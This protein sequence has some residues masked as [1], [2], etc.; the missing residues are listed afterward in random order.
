MALCRTGVHIRFEF[1]LRTWCSGST[2]HGRDR[3]YRIPVERIRVSS[4]VHS[5]VFLFLLVTVLLRTKNTRTVPTP[6]YTGTGTRTPMGIGVWRCTLLEQN[7]VAP[8][9]RRIA[10]GQPATTPKAT[11][12]AFINAQSQWKRRWPGTTRFLVSNLSS[13]FSSSSCSSSSLRSD[14]GLKRSLSS[15]SK[16]WP[17][18]QDRF[19]TIQNANG[20]LELLTA[21]Q[22]VAMDATR[23]WT[24]KNVVFAANA[25]PNNY[26]VATSYDT[27]TT[28]STAAPG[29]ASASAADSAAVLVLLVS[30]Q[31][32]P[33]LLFT[34]RSAQLSH[35]AAEISFPGG[36]CDPFQDATVVDT[37]VREAIEELYST[38]NPSTTPTTTA[39]TTN[40][41]HFTKPLHILGSA[42]PIP[43]LRGIPIT[44]I[45]AVWDE[46]LPDLSLWPGN[47][48][49]VDVVFAVS[50]QELTK[51][52]TTR[53]LSSSIGSS[54]G[55]PSHGS[56]NS[57]ANGSSRFQS[58]NFLKQQATVFPSPHGDIWG[59]T[60]YILRPI[61]HQ[62]LRPVFFPP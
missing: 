51:V 16:A 29:A 31:G 24:T 22:T 41:N 42:T 46:E 36:H 13:F 33:S 56:N 59:L 38:N 11:F 37:A 43:S 32:Q 58:S 34:R 21:S 23:R 9:C 50:L 49:E 53:T 47:P 40:E 45:L 10:L 6:I 44:P 19:R 28:G 60:A 39:A 25:E 3:Q 26:V 27:S 52:E 7:G 48:S 18:L 14:D 2:T 57:N 61:L 5:F 15:L 35:H 55:A 62:L 4:V 20:E 12:S 1:E 17:L 8:K 54:G 30:V